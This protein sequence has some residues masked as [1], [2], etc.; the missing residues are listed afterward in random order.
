VIGVVGA[1]GLLATFSFS[2]DS[3][4]EVGQTTGAALLV[5]PV[6]AR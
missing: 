3:G 2:T 5:G 4:T 1:F 6:A